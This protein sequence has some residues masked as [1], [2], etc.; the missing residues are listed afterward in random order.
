MATGDSGTADIEMKMAWRRSNAKWDDAFLSLA[1]HLNLPS[2]QVTLRNNGAIPKSLRTDAP[3]YPIPDWQ[4]QG[5]F[6][7]DRALIFAFMRQESLFDAQAQSWAG[8]RGVM[9]LMPATASF[10]GRDRSLSRVNKSKLFEPEFNMALGQKYLRHL[11]GTKRIQDNLFLVMAA[12]NGGP[13]NLNKWLRNSK[14]G[15]DWLLFIETIPAKET[16]IYIER[17]MANY[18]IYRQRLNQPTPSL[19]AVASGN[20]PRYR[21]Q[22]FPITK[23]A[24]SGAQQTQ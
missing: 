17:V 4:P 1:T 18:W 6:K 14:H 24:A 21:G 16:R 15:D 7:L 19:Q 23:T 11:M 12:Y 10:I 8:A 2:T 5:G 3:L 13:G 20:D 9:Q 22:E